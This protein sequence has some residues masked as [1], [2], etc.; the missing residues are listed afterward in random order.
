M[1]AFTWASW[2]D[3]WPPWERAVGSGNQV[4]PRLTSLSCRR[5]PGAGHPA[6]SGTVS[7]PCLRIICVTCSREARVVPHRSL[8]DDGTAWVRVLE[9]RSAGTTPPPWP[10][11]RSPE[12]SFQGRWCPVVLGRSEGAEAAGGG[13]G[14][15]L[16]CA[17]AA[18]PASPC[19]GHLAPSAP[20]PGGAHVSRPQ[21][22]PPWGCNTLL[23]EL[24]LFF[25]FSANS[26]ATSSTTT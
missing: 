25:V 7:P 8:G 1:G 15:G 19:P 11:V 2:A 4:S 23:D 9:A 26:Q 20:W 17:L 21:T 3:L 14:P 24:C 10:P 16:R 6:L 18:A 13:Q 12:A 22:R 5:G